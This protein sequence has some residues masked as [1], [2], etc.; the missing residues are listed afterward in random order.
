LSYKAEEAAALMNVNLIGVSNSIAAVL[1][2]MLER[3]RGHVVGLSSLASFRG[4]PRMLAYCASKAGLNALLAGLRVEV[5][6]YN[7]TVTTICP[8]W[9]RTPMTAH[10]QNP[11]VQKL[12]LE[13]AV[14]EIAGAIHRRVAFF[15]F[16]RSMARRLR[17]LNWLPLGLADRLVASMARDLD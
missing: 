3:K 4:L 13:A 17:F 9:I 11:R 16:P 6:P 2:G 10:I 1:P 8:G 12:E 14:Q 7:V 5:K 15:A